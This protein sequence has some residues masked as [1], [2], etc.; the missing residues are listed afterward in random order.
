MTD[1]TQAEIDG[2]P[3]DSTSILVGTLTTEWPYQ[4]TP[5]G[6]HDAL[7]Q[8]RCAPQHATAHIFL[9]ASFQAWLAYFLA[10]SGNSRHHRGQ[11]AAQ[12]SIA[13]LEELS[14]ED[15]KTVADE[16][17]RIVPHPTVPNESEILP[18]A[19]KRRQTTPTTERFSNEA[20]NE[21]QT[22]HQT[23]LNAAFE[24]AL[25]NHSEPGHTIFNPI[26]DEVSDN[27]S[28]RVSGQQTVSNP[29]AKRLAGIF[30][31]YTCGAIRNSGNTA[32]VTMAFPAQLS[33][34]KV[35]CLMSLSI[36]PN[37]IQYLAMVLFEVHIES[38]AGI[39]YVILDNG[40]RVLPQNE[41]VLQGGKEKGIETLL[42]PEPTRALR[43]SPLRKDEIRQGKL[44][45]NC[46]TLRLPSNCEYD[47][48]L[49]LNL[50][51][52]EA[53]RLKDTLFK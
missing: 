50:G 15:R 42:G 2:R 3:H 51:L 19:K 49:N 32:S 10:T 28:A 13:A 18:R 39:W 43:K 36:L 5:N 29:S 20:Q 41:V 35:E 38:D 27:I 34:P 11:S 31:Q 22:A 37:K 4:R 7:E 23:A 9:H 21:L 16:V 48:I 33:G 47:G 40:V 12:K 30:P 1:S 52:D 24:S 26:A 53:F 14:I 17:T 44:A 25:D 8:A 46:V 6:F 45:T